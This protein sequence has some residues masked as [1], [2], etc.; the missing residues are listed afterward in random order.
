M[1]ILIT[2]ASGFIGS[3]IVEEA[4]KQ[5]FET[6]AAVR[7]TSSRQYLQDG[8]IHFIELDFSSRQRL[9][10]Q[11]KGH[12]FD[13]IVHAAGTTKC[14]DPTNFYKINY[15]G[16]KNLAEAL[17]A[18]QMPI[19]RFVYLSSLSV[20]GAIKERQPYQEITE[21]DIPR[22]NTAYGKSKLE[23]ERFLDSIGSS[24][25]YIILRPTGVYGPREKDYFLMAKSI[26]AHTDFSVGFRR[27]DITF[28]YVKDVVQAVF[29]AL[30]RGMNGRKYFLSDG[31]VYQSSTFSNYIREELGRPWWIRVKAPVWV[32]RIVT[33]F[34]ELIA[35]RTGKISALNNDKYNILRQRNWRCDIEP[36]VDE[37]GYKPRFDLKEGTHLAIKW[38]KENQWL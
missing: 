20:F 35:R 38:Y 2:G 18:L 29:L 7:K 10:E 25:P 14:L 12:E 13:Y 28:V 37:L 4:L 34:G 31:K 19:R 9:E 36:A 30:D 33:Y 21:H 11:L 5:G 16:T 26:K 15:E 23:A 24:F 6:W 8:R 17:I 22:P 3:F 1:K 32:L 27:Q